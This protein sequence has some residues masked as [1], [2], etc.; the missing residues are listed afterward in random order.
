M[1]N[2]HCQT[3]DFLIL[4]ATDFS[5]PV[6]ICFVNLLEMFYGSA[7]AVGGMALA[8]FAFGLLIRSLSFMQAF[9]LAGMRLVRIEMKVAA[10]AAITNIILNILLIP[11]YGIEGAALASAAAFTVATLL[12]F[13]YL[14]ILRHTNCL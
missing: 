10:A 7:Y 4:S 13:H 8:I 11:K 12:F 6:H 5:Y 9:T 14:I 2:W 3:T 1:K